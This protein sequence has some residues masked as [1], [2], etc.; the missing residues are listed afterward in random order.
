MCRRQPRTDDGQKKGEAMTKQ[1][2]ATCIYAYWSLRMKMRSFAPGFPCGPLCANHP[3]TPGQLRQV[4]SAGLCRNYRPKPT[5]T[6]GDIKRIP[7]G[8]SQYALVDAADYERLSKYNW[9]LQ[10]GYAARQ[11]KSKMI[12]LHREIMRPPEGLIVDHINHNKLDDCRINLRV[13]TRR[14][15]ILNQGKKCNSSSRFKGLEYCRRRNRWYVRIRFR[16]GRLWVGSFTDE[17]EAAHAYDCKAVELFGEFAHLNF[18][19]EWP[20]EKRQQVYAAAQPLRDALMAKAKAEKGKGKKAKGKR[21]RAR[22]KTP[23]RKGRKR[24]TKA[25]KSEGGKV[26]YAPGDEQKG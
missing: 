25:R 5:A 15:N 24:S 10:N 23:K 9:R 21:T 13:C 20:L 2:C 12:Y 7:L 19:E 22:T 1:C 26:R 4:S 11:E 8:E 16:G 3:D 6:E 18:P 14:E 17:V